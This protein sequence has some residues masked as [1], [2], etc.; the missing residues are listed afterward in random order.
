MQEN[1][2]LEALCRIFVGSERPETFSF[3]LRWVSQDFSELNQFWWSN[4]NA[5]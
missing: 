2:A 4:L 5:N 3:S 1:S